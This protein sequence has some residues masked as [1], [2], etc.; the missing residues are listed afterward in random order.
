MYEQ[1]TDLLPAGF[2]PD[3]LSDFMKAVDRMRAQYRA[4]Q[5]QADRCALEKWNERL[6]AAV[7]YL[8]GE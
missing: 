2:P 5:R 3:L 4:A 6:K 1:K 7:R 8:I